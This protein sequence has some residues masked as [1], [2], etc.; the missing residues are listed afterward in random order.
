MQRFVLFVNQLMSGARYTTLP[1]PAAAGYSSWGVD[2]ATLPQLF[3]S[4][5]MPSVLVLT[6]FRPL[7]SAVLPNFERPHEV[8]S[9]FRPRDFPPLSGGGDL[10]TSTVFESGVQSSPAVVNQDFSKIDLS[11]LPSANPP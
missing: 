10:V 7:G 11:A 8:D 9:I 2:T 5:S 6:V 3:S 4:T 1:S